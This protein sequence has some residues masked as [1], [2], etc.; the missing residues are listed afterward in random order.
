MSY[1]MLLFIKNVFDVFNKRKQ[2]FFIYKVYLMCI[3]K[4]NFINY[5][6]CNKIE[7]LKTVILVGRYRFITNVI[8]ELIP[9]CILNCFIV[10]AWVILSC[11]LVQ[12]IYMMCFSMVHA[13]TCNKHTKEESQ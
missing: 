5:I 11:T 3:L 1:V 13:V 2:R 8:L 12:K 4:N 9:N 10:C 6:S 7:K